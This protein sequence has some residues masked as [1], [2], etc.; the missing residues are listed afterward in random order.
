[1]QQTAA[2]GRRYRRRASACAIAVSFAGY[3]ADLVVFDP[4]KVGET[5]LIREAEVVRDRRRPS[6]RDPRASAGHFHF[7]S[8][9]CSRQLSSST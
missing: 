6:I 2:T 3:A 7:A 4:A 8:T 1:V 5:K 9:G